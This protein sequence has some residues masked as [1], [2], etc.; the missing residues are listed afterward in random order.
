MTSQKRWLLGLAAAAVSVVVGANPASAH[1]PDEYGHNTY[2]SIT[3]DGLRLEM[4]LTPG[5]LV[6]EQLVSVIDANHDGSFSSDEITQYGQRIARDLV[7]SVDSTNRPVTL[8]ALTKPTPLDVRSGSGELVFTAIAPGPK[9]IKTFSF[10]DNHLVLKGPSQASVLDEHNL[11]DDLA[12]NRSVRRTIIVSG[13]FSPSTQ[14]SVAGGEPSGQGT[15]PKTPVSTSTNR[16]KRLQR[17]LS[18]SNSVGAIAAALG[19]AALLGALHALT[20]G[21]GKT[22]A[23]AYLIGEKATVR[24]AVILGLSVTI[25]HT[26]SVLILGAIAIG[27]TGRIDPG[28][29]TDGLRWV[30]GTLVLGI[31]LNLLIRRIR[32]LNTAHGHGH[33]HAGHDHSHAGHDHVDHGGHDHAV[34][35]DTTTVRRVV[36]LGASGGVIPCPEALGVM[37]VAVSIHRQ[38]F[39]MAM[40]VAF[41]VGLAS[42]LVAVG[43]TIVRARTVIDRFTKL[44]K[45]ITLRWLPIFSST[46]VSLLGLAILSGRVV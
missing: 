7:V 22:I 46:V 5:P 24:H 6:G 1:A 35:A 25:T 28:T 4:H 20:P 27:L 14:T 21:H 37:I 36:A 3:A 29:L 13:T 10:Q 40:I 30:S 31:G 33:H 19:V 23:G 41:S 9:P 42:I 34:V 44:P 12:I 45:S 18:T 2:I 26:A 17:I 16:T 38:V 8:I 43:I 11:P 32:G 39:G 15:E